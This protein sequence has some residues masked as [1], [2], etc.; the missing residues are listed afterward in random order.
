MICEQIQTALMGSGGSGQKGSAIAMWRTSSCILGHFEV[1][2]LLASEQ[3]I[4]WESQLEAV[5]PHPRVSF[6]Q[7]V[8]QQSAKV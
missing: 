6:S 1:A 4:S 8:H 7:R 5:V 2:L 3:S